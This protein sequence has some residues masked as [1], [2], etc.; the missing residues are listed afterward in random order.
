MLSVICVLCSVLAINWLFRVPRGF[1]SC[2]DVKI[3]AHLLQTV[4]ASRRCAYKV[5]TCP[6]WLDLVDFGPVWSARGYPQLQKV[7]RCFSAFT[8][9]SASEI[10]RN[11]AN[12][13]VN[14]ETSHG[15]LQT[16]TLC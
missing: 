8:Q 12:L 2:I 5:K 7:T 13:L 16:V 9:D 1:S 10:Q 4:N 15:R 3:R 11:C 14:A 6:Q